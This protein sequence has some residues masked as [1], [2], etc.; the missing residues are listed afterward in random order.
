MSATPHQG[1][2]FRF[3]GLV[4]LLNSSLFKDAQDMVD[5]RHRLNAVVI[6]RTK[7]DACMQDGN[8]F[9][10]ETPSAHADPSGGDRPG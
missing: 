2:H 4:N 6:R 3:W 1:N 8:S 9:Y 7:A 5:N 10:I